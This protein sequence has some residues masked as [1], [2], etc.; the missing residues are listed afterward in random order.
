MSSNRRLRTAVVGLGRLGMRHAGNL[1]RRTPEVEVIAACSPVDGERAAAQALGIRSVHARYEDVLADPAVEAVV[2]V[3][4]TSL[5]ADQIIQALAAGKHV[6]SEKPLALTVAD[7]LRVE[8]AAAKRPDRVVMIGFVRRFDPSYRNA[9]DKIAGGAI[10]SPFMV[11]SQTTDQ[12]D[13]SGFFVK[14]APTSGGIFLDCSIHDIDITRWFFAQGSEKPPRALR[15]Q[16]AGTIA[17]HKGLAACGDVDNGIATVEFADGRLATFF[18]SRTMAHGQDTHTEVFGT[19]G[20]IA[21]GVGAHLNR[22]EICDVNGMRHECPPEFWSRF[23]EAFGIE[24]QTFARAVL[25]GAPSPVTL[26]DATE[27]TRIGVAI[28]TA[29]REKRVVEIDGAR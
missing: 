26:F 7:C 4:P 16:A 29:F 21:I 10:G 23:H 18:T 20:S 5:H 27:A 17:I 14:F 19:G 25:D 11:R 15:A 1:A 2:L 8:A 22:V 13:P 28:T 6:F 24:M 9:A 3:T 12:N